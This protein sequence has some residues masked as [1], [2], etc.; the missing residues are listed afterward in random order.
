[1]SMFANTYTQTQHLHACTFETVPF[2][3]DK[4]EGSQKSL[5]SD[6]VQEAN[7][8]SFFEY[9]YTHAWSN[10]V[11]DELQTLICLIWKSSYIQ[12]HI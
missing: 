7:G 12:T 3:S 1:M 5:R 11:K 2:E 9:S 10:S 8:M 4:K 6:S